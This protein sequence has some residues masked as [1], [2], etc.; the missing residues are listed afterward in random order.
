[1]GYGL[2]KF[3]K[4][5]IIEKSDWGIFYNNEGLL[6]DEVIIVIDFYI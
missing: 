6:K 5:F 2:E 1:M 3:N 4:K